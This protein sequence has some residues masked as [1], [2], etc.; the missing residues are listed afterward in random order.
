MEKNH[1]ANNIL[2]NLLLIAVV[3][4]C[5]VIAIAL[6]I[7]MDSVGFTIAATVLAIA[8]LYP[9]CHDILVWS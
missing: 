6:S 2:A 3:L 9:L 1:R 5:D 7:S 8:G 4:I